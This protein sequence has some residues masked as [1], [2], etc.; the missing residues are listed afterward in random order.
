MDGQ[1]KILLSLRIFRRG[2]QDA[3]VPA[4]LAEGGGDDQ[5]SRPDPV[6]Q[7]F[8]GCRLLQDEVDVLHLPEGDLGIHVEFPDGFD[9]IVKE[10]QTYGIGGLQ[11]ENVQNAAAAGPL[12]A[13]NDL[14][15]ALES[16]FREQ[17]F[18]FVRRPRFPRLQDHALVLHAPGG[19]NLVIQG[20]FRQ[21]DGQPAYLSG[22]N[23][24]Q[25]VQPFR[26]E[27][28]VS[29]FFA[30]RHFLFRDEQDV[31][32]APC[33]QLGGYGFLGS[34]MGSH[35]PGAARFR[36]AVDAQGRHKR[37]AGQRGVVENGLFLRAQLRQF[38]A[39]GGGAG[40]PVQQGGY[41][42]VFCHTC[43]K[44]PVEG[45]LPP[46]PAMSTVFQGTCVLRSRQGTGRLQKRK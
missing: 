32:H 15:N 19:G 43:L 4:F 26:G 5:V 24:V 37:Y 45:S 35:H 21:N 18:Q 41:G 2:G 8:H 10:F 3:H 9:F 17:L 40:H 1:G 33:L 39:E 16:G 27:F 42:S 29:H 34:Q 6:A 28:R 12:P 23:A 30:Q 14:R 46:F 22:G 13:G 11:G 20:I 36:N 25:H 38:P 44:A 31:V 7:G